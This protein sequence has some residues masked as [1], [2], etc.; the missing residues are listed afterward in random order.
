MIQTPYKKKE[1]N[2]VFC[3]NGRKAEKSTRL[4]GVV[5]SENWTFDDH[6]DQVVRRMMQ[7]IPHIRAIRHSVSREVLLRVS[8][9]LIMSIFNFACDIT[10]QK[11]LIQRRIQK[12]Q[13]CLL[14]VITNSD[15][16][17]SIEY[18]EC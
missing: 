9:A 11:K 17:R 2:E 14:R 7:R 1:E 15:R 3:L 13:N 8:D 6:A 16:L 12:V 5:V 18:R 10:S 4:L